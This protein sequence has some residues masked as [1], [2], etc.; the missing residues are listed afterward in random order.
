MMKHKTHNIMRLEQMCDRQEPTL[1]QGNT[2]QH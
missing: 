1:E 2:F